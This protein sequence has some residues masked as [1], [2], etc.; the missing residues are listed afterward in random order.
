VRSKTKVTV[1]TSSRIFVSPSRMGTI[2]LL[3]DLMIKPILK[4][5]ILRAGRARS[6]QGRKDTG[7]LWAAD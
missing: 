7:F 2:A 5:R 6:R 1:M 3:E 4:V